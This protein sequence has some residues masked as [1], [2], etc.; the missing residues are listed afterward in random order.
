MRSISLVYLTLLLPIS[1]AAQVPTVAVVTAE[2][3]SAANEAYQ[4]QDW[5][6]AAERYEKII[7][8]EEKNAGARYRY[9]TALLN[10]NRNADAV[11]NLE[12][13]MSIS[14]NPIFALAAARGYA[15]TE[16]KEKMYEV[17]EKSITLGGIAP[18]SLTGEKDFASVLSEPKFADFVKRS[19]L[20]VNPCKAKPEFR[21]FDFWIGEWAPK[22]VQGVTVGSSS[23]QLI[24]GSCIIFENWSTPVS[25]GKS[26]NLFDTRDGKWHQTW[27]DDKGLMTHYVGGLVDGRMVLTSDTLANGK[28][29]LAKM[30]FSKLDNGDVRQH[31]ENSSD[32]GKTWTTTFDFIYVRKK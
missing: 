28:K 27:V 7:K 15:R 23:I 19:D 18:E 14:P 5:P 29:T 17:L 4:K 13:A 11:R 30:T 12:M 22:N 21:Q 10:L 6:A 8:I 25:S 2:M 1:I 31:G 26:F 24:L 20:T 3:R 9:G 16:N 32:E